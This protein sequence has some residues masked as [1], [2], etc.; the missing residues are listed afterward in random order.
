MGGYSGHGAAK[1]DEPYVYEPWY[2][3]GIGVLF[4]EAVIAIGVSI[5][6]VSM[7]LSGKT[8]Q[9][10]KTVVFEKK[11]AVVAPAQAPT[12]IADKCKAL[13]QQLKECQPA[14]QSKP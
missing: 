14:E 4:L 5:F 8:V 10:K 6:S 7:G 11:P 2:K 3:Y 13:E 12:A 1:R 9:F